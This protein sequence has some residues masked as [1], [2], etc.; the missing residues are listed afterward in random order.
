MTF[1]WTQQTMELLSQLLDVISK[2]IK[3]WQSFNSSNGD[4]GYFSR[5]ESLSDISQ[6]RT[7][8]S[9]R[10]INETFQNLKSLQQTLLLLEKSCRQS[11]EAVRLCHFILFTPIPFPSL[12]EG[13]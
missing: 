12:K 5:I 7:R 13:Y 3:A 1:D 4:I 9:L 10:A 8:L 2:P 11:A 6:C